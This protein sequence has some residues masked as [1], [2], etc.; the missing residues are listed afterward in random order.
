M[1]SQTPTV[2]E[3]DRKLRDDFRRRVKDYGVS[4]EVTDPL[5][6][7]LFR[8]FAQQIDDVYSD[9]AQLRASL[10]HELMQGLHVE[11]YLARPAQAV[12]RLVNGLGEPRHLRAGTELN[13]VAS[14][15]ERLVFSLDADVEISRAQ[16]AFALSYQEQAIRVLS[17]VEMSDAVQAMRPS[18]E[19]L[20]INLG[21][22]AALF[23]AIE[24]LS[25]S[26]LSRH[27]IFFEF[28]PETYAVQHALSHEPW[29]IFGPDGELASEGLMRSERINA[30]V[31]R[32]AFQLDRTAVTSSDDQPL[33]SIP[34]GFYAG[35]Q[36]L[37][38][39]MNS[40]RP[41]LCRA[42]SRLEPVLEKMFSRDAAQLLAVPR[43]WIKIPMPP[44]VPA[45]H[46]AINGIALHT[47]T[48]SN[49]FARNQTLRFARDGV[50]V[51]VVKAGGAPEHLVAPLSV[52]SAENEPYERGHGPRNRIASGWYEISNGRLTISPGADRD[53]SPHAAANVRLWLTNGELGNKVGPGDITGFA[54]AASLAGL[55]LTQLTAAS[56]GTNGDSLATEQRPFCRCPAYAKSDRNAR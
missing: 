39:S 38:P 4:S 7:V 46:H 24:G 15:G 56:G 5:L 6:A 20:P 35:R 17:G 26:L 48:V 32:L 16:I 51:P 52:M 2:L 34:D 40:D 30:G 36:F 33:P 21:P 27:G 8:T 54:H 1:S 44:G 9:T 10:L 18:L 49:V 3:I 43:V 42:P 25:P 41:L 29:W 13:A 50:S 53:G 14:S 11:Q 55:R 22:Q 23:L 45:L 31:C 37:F 19:P 12:V 28:G 47:M